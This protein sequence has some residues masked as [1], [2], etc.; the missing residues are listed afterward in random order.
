MPA[1]PHQVFRRNSTWK[2]GVIR[3]LATDVVLHGRI[4]TTETRAKE[5]RKHVDHLITLAKKD[6]LASRRR[7]ESFL[8]PVSTKEGQTVGQYLFK[9]VGPK[10]KD[11]K[12]G[13][14]RI[15]K[16]PMRRG[17]STKMAVIELV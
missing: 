2:M 17:D 14:T 9:T 12:G 4:T 1:N 5:L 11:R 10:Y 15:V 7:A 3:T 13:Y 8:R 6:T 16:A